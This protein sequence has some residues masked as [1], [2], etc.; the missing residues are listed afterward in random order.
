MSEAQ[1]TRAG[2][3]G[4]QVCIPAAWTDEQAKEF[5]DAENFCG[6]ANGWQVRKE[7]SA[8]LNGDPERCPCAERAGFVHLMLDA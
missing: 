8:L 4:M 7:G 5:A 2:L 3:L 1:V 6:T